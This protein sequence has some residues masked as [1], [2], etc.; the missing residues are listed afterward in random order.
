MPKKMK[1]AKK[2][3]RSPLWQPGSRLPLLTTL[4]DAMLASADDQYHALQL[5]RQHASLLDASAAGHVI[6]VFTT[7]Q[8]ILGLYDAQVQHWRAETLTEAQRVDL[9]HLARH[10]QRLHTVIAAVLTLANELK[11]HTK[12]AGDKRSFS[13]RRSWAWNAC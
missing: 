1:Q 13:R 6:T 3:Q 7:Q 11:A 2:N 12:G 5:A 8:D 10:L 4:I 9:E